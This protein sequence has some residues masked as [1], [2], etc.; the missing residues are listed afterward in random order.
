MK[1]PYTADKGKTKMPPDLAPEIERQG[2]KYGL[3]IYSSRSKPLVLNKSPDTLLQFGRQL[4]VPHPLFGVSP[5]D[6]PFFQSYRR[7]LE[8]S[9]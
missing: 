6:S 5:L 8:I 4:P 2:L 7:G 1:N 9:L 3:L